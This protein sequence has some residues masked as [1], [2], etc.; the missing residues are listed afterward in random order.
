MEQSVIG[1]RQSHSNSKAVAALVLGV[2]AMA[3]VVGSALLFAY[4]ISNDGE[5]E[6]WW[7]LL[8][9]FAFL[10]GIMAAFLGSIGWIDVRRGITDKR[11]FEAQFGALLGGIAALIV[12]LATAALFLIGVLLMFSFGTDGGGLD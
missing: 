2:F 5:G 11:L 4:S 9:F 3:N 6:G 8:P 7:I 10:A 1:P 12:V